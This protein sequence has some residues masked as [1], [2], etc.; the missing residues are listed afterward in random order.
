MSG[1]RR[2]ARRHLCITDGDGFIL[3]YERC[4]TS[5]ASESGLHDTASRGIPL[6]TAA[7]T[8]FFKNPTHLP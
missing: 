3:V 8:R 7:S 5:P 4:M 1:Q 2:R 6:Q